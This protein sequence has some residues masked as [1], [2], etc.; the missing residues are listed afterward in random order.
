M[1]DQHT[2]SSALSS[3]QAALRHAVEQLDELA[4]SDDQ[5]QHVRAQLEQQT[6][7]LQTMQ[8]SLDE[9]EAEKAREH[10]QTLSRSVFC[11]IRT[12]SPFD[13]PGVAWCTTQHTCFATLNDKCCMRAD[14][15]ILSS[16]TLARAHVSDSTDS[17]FSCSVQISGA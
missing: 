13:S 4:G 16:R 9:S 6:E 14:C 15:H 11:D 12:L 17:S 8:R 3:T 10:Q 1:T 5:M 7:A 2:E